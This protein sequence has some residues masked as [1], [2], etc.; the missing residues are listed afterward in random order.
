MLVAPASTGVVPSGTG[1][2]QTYTEGQQS[3]AKGNESI[4]EHVNAAGV[5]V[6]DK[7]LCN[8]SMLFQ[9]GVCPGWPGRTGVANVVSSMYCCVWSCPE[10][11]EG[12]M[13]RIRTRM[14]GAGNVMGR[15]TFV[16]VVPI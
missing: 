4:R 11:T 6:G 13:H 9:N 14:P 16:E 5:T 3:S 15:S 1:S 8:F 10:R 7:K 12:Y 2:P